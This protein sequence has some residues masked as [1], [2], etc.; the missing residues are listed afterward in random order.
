MR[1]LPLVLPILAFA[2]GCPQ[3]AEEPP[4]EAEPGEV[5]DT[6]AYEADTSRSTTWIG[7]EGGTVRHPSGMACIDIPAGAVTDSV[8][9]TVVAGADANPPTARAGADREV[10]EGEFV[11]IDGGASS[12]P[13]G[14]PLT[15]RWTILSVSSPTV[16]LDSIAIDD[17]AAASTRFQVPRFAVS[18]GLDDVLRNR[19]LAEHVAVRRALVTAAEASI[20]DASLGLSRL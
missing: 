17:P 4:E 13:D 2:V 7:P 14:E 8:R 16:P 5:V 18:A 12:D 3:P 9:V 6:T 1:K 20:L 10:N 15:F 19:A 11:S